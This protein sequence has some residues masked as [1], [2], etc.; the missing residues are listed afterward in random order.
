MDK[1]ISIVMPV[2]N[3]GDYLDE[4]LESVRVQTHKNWEL[5]CIDDYSTDQSYKKLQG[6]SKKDKRIKV[7]RNGAHKGVSYAANLA[8]SKACGEFIARMDADDVMLPDRV[9]KQAKFLQENP[10]VIAVG[11]QCLL[12]N[13]EGRE[14]GKKVFPEQHEKVYDMIYRAIP[15]QQPALMVDKTRLPKDF[16][17]Y[18]SNLQYG[19]EVDLLFRLFNYGRC[20]NLG[21]YLL[22]YRI[23]DKNVSLLHPKKTFLVTYEARKRAVREYGYKPTPLSRAISFLQRVA[24]GILPEKLVFPL[25]ALW[26][27][28]VPINLSLLP[29]LS[30]FAPKPSKS[31]VQKRLSVV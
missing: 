9:E 2:Y 30:F 3:A 18:Q 6:Y 8:I 12:I 4:A 19:E 25:F 20:A 24:V 1:L 17:W 28:I 29:K 27:G 10:D 11:G 5:I 7:Y 31:V 13:K 15:I 21:A 26:R 22:K 23:H 16:V 14:I